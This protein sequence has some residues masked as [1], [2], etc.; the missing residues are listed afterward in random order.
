[1]YS[2]WLWIKASALCLYS[3][4]SASSNV[5]GRLLLTSI[6]S[7][8]VCVFFFPF[9]LHLCCLL[10]LHSQPQAQR[11]QSI[12]W[13]H[14][15]YCTQDENFQS[16]APVRLLDDTACDA[17]K[18][19]CLKT[20]LMIY[21]L[22]YSIQLVRKNLSL[23]LLVSIFKIYCIL[24]RSRQTRYPQAELHVVKSFFFFVKSFVKVYEW[25]FSAVFFILF[26]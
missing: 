19:T 18:Q 16:Q 20:R 6:D 5:S 21:I 7:K 8:Q 15:E 1:M 17:S 3:S 14:H 13:P 10:A 4:F 26:F 23:D 24:S 22:F 12:D 11:P 2:T 9:L 25:L